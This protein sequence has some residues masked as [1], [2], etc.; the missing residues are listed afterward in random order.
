MRATVQRR[1]AWCCHRVNIC[2]FVCYSQSPFDYSKRTEKIAVHQPPDSRTDTKIRVIVA[3]D[4]AMIRQGLCSVLIQYSDILVVGEAANGEDAIALA[5]HLQPDVM[6]MDIHLPK[7]DGIEAT[8][9]LKRTHPGVVVIG[10]SAH[11]TGP[12]ETAMKAAG[13]TAFVNKEEAVEKLYH[14]I[15]VAREV[16]SAGPIP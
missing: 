9:L 16:L 3:D 14:T 8:R 13:A 6:L 1:K 11:I 12:V 2:R 15:L 5:D 10:L 4:H 7:L